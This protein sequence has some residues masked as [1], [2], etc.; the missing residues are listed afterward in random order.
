MNVDRDV[1]IFKMAGSVVVLH[2]ISI[3]FCCGRCLVESN[4][5]PECFTLATL[6][7]GACDWN[8][9]IVDRLGQTCT[10]TGTATCRMI[11]VAIRPYALS[12]RF[13]VFSL[14]AVSGAFLQY[15][16]TRLFDSPSNVTLTVGVSE[17]VFCLQPEASGPVPTSIQWYNPQGQLVS[18]NNRDEVNQVAGTGGGRAALLT[19]QSYHQSQGGKYECRVAGP[20]NNTERLPVCIGECH[21]W[22]DS[23]GLLSSVSS[24]CQIKLAGKSADVHKPHEHALPLALCGVHIHQ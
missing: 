4:S 16:S 6:I 10:G 2:L 18:R 5:E 15:G 22:G 21:A 17:R 23:C 24:I 11:L 13:D 3:S 14:T 8:K 12:V 1:Y 7:G 9:R 19:F 20:G